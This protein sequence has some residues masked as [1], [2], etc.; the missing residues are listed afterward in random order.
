MQHSLLVRFALDLQV[1]KEIEILAQDEG[2][3]RAGIEAIGAIEQ[4]IFPHAFEFDHRIL[5]IEKDQVNV[6]E[7]VSGQV[8]QNVQFLGAQTCITWTNCQVKVA[9]GVNASARRRA[10]QVYSLD[11]R[12][13]P[14]NIRQQTQIG[15]NRRGRFHDYLDRINAGVTR[16][17]AAWIRLSVFFQS[18]TREMLMGEWV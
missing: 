15:K 7:A 18:S 12:I 1:G 6:A 8:R 16:P 9:F 11:A 10:K 2:I 14:E 13:F 5:C 3:E 4:M 17:S